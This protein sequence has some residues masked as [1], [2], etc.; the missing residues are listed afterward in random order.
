[1]STK[2]TFLV[3]NTSACFFMGLISGVFFYA[4]LFFSDKFLN[5]SL[6]R[7]LGPINDHAFVMFIYA[8]LYILF[9]WGVISIINKN[10]LINSERNALTTLEKNLDSCR[11]IS[12]RSEVDNLRNRILHSG[13]QAQKIRNSMVVQTLLFLVDHCLVTET[14]KKVLGIFTKRLDTLEKHIE[15]SYNILRYIAWAIPS[16]GFIGTVMGIGA[17]LSNVD[18]IAQDITL[19]TKP[20]GTAFDTTLIALVES[21]VLMYFLYSTQ[22]KEEDLLNSVDLF[23]QEKFIINLSLGEKK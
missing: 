17:A 16:L 6:G 22:R 8:S 2:K 20:L 13:S 11:I 3:P 10:I 23:C 4:V 19:V 9:F 1:M 14:S 21:M 18:F 7:M 12:Q 5:V 15:S